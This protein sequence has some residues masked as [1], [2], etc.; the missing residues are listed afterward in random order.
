M[1]SRPGSQ[2]PDNKKEA[3][4]HPFYPVV[5]RHFDEHP[6]TLRLPFAVLNRH[7]AMLSQEFLQFALSGFVEEQKDKI[8][9]SVDCVALNKLYA[10]IAAIVGESIMER[11]NRL[12]TEQFLAVPVSIGFAY[13]L[14]CALVDSLTYVANETGKQIFL[15]L[16]DECSERKRG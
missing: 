11:L 4:K 10:E 12:L 6:D 8:Y 7:Y 16:M 13:G 3:E 1:N 15:H 9:R 2:S 5:K 14:S